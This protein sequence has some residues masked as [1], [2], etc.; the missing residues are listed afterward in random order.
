MGSVSVLNVVIVVVVPIISIV[1]FVTD[2]KNI[3]EREFLIW[4]SYNLN[5][6]FMSAKIISVIFFQIFNFF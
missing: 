2:F 3:L 4:T 1:I 5:H 6:G